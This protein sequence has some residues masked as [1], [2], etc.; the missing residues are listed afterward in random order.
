MEIPG[1]LKS[2]SCDS[3]VVQH[4]QILIGFWNARTFLNEFLWT[5]WCSVGKQIT[6]TRQIIFTFYV[7][8]PSDL[9]GKRND[10]ALFSFPV[11]G[12]VSPWMS[13]CLHLAWPWQ[14]YRDVKY[15]RSGT[16]FI[17]GPKSSLTSLCLEDCKKCYL[18]IPLPKKNCAC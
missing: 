11:F 14:G 7:D 16:P 15:Q 10:F 12:H 13:R 5:P 8:N 18:F 1:E 4:F 9:S 17:G 2:Q 6:F 3:N